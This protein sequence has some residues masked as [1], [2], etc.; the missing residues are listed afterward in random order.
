MKIVDF[1]PLLTI[2]NGEIVLGWYMSASLSQRFHCEKCSGCI[3]GSLY[4]IG[5]TES[6]CVFSTMAWHCWYLCNFY[7]SYNVYN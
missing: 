3:L 2:E 5:V 1:F 4:L 6:Q 7:Y